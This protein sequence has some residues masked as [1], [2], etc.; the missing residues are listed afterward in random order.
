MLFYILCLLW[1]LFLL[2]LENGSK[3]GYME[4]TTFYDFEQQMKNKL[5][6][7]VSQTN[8]YRN[9]VSLPLTTGPQQPAQALSLPPLPVLEKGMDPFQYVIHQVEPMYPQIQHAID[10]LRQR[11][12]QANVLTTHL[13]FS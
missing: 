3:E 10:T 1:F 9:S 6:T 11:Q 5:N 8:Y 4:S 7:L 2:F 13:S 12:S